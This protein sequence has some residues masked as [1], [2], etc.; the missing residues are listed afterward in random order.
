MTCWRKG[1]WQRRGRCDNQKPSYSGSVEFTQAASKTR[2]HCKPRQEPP[3][4]LNP[5]KDPSQWMLIAIVLRML[6]NLRLEAYRNHTCLPSPIKFVCA[7]LHIW[8]YSFLLSAHQKEAL[9]SILSG[10]D[11]FVC[12]PT[13]HGK[14][15]ILSTCRTARISCALTVLRRQE[16]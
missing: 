15:I 8:R 5:C 7:N 12:L 16:K 3:F 6:W 2:N 11:T 1:F 9:K 13:G 10:K 14:S 4:P